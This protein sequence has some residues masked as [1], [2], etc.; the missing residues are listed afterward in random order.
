MRT[1]G[2][3]A[4]MIGQFIAIVLF[5]G[6]AVNAD[7]HRPTL[8]EA[9]LWMALVAIYVRVSTPTDTDVQS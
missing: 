7:G 4:S 5:V 3:Y 6:A 2:I 8:M 9:A 1:I